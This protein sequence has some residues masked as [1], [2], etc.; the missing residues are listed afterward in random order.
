MH[1]QQGHAHWRRTLAVLCLLCGAL[2]FQETG[3]LPVLPTIQRQLA[4]AGT[5]SS[6]LLESGFLMVAA[7]AAPLIGKLGDDRGKQRMLLVTLAVYF[8]GALGAALAPDFLV[9]VIFRSLQGV[10]GALFSLSFA[11]MRDEASE[12]LSVAIG[13]LVG[14]FGLGAC[15]GLGLSGLITEAL[16]WRWIFFAETLLIVAGAGLVAWLVPARPGSHRV[17]IDYVGLALLAGSLIVLIG[18]LTVMLMLGWPVFAL[19]LVA[20]ALFLAWLRHERRVEQPL[21]DT[22]VLAKP[23]VLLAN[24]GSGLAGYVGFAIYFLVP[25]FVQTPLHL[26][27]EVAA[28]VHYGFGA[29]ALA[30]GLYLLPVG[31]G[32]LCAGPS[33]GVIGR[34]IGGKWPF[35]GGLLLMA[36]G[37]ALLACFHHRQVPFAIWLFLIGAGFGFSVGA[38]GVFITQSVKAGETAIAT[39]F[40]SVTRLVSGGIGAEVAAS[41]LKSQGIGNS[42]TP[43]ELAFVVA[44]G[45]G[46]LLALVGC[47]V[48]LLVPPG[49]D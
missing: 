30:V 47:G 5:V 3:V 49:K 41:I 44:F 28:Q 22:R 7:V 9:L 14:A 29:E 16:S 25:R 32:V 23:R 35:A 21:L 38:A 34:R 46:A 1:D 12:R 17:R 27:A 8:V 18:A 11:I 4:G 40:N 33:G 19:F 15:L 24:I 6:A 43:H 42:S 36:L 20:I 31:V 26:P 13:W 45:I 48:A 2:A 10:G 39:A 37:S